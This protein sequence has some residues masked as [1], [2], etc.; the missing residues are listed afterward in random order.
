MDILIQSTK[1]FEQDLEKF[2]KIEQ[3]TI[4]KNM[5]KC[6]EFLSIDRNSFDAYSKQFKQLKLNHNYDSSL[7]SL[8][9]N[10][11]IQVILTIDDDPIFDRTLI[12]LFRVVNVE[13]AL[14]A[15]NSVAEAIYQDFTVENQEVE[16]PSS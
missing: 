11:K 1:E 15:Y 3:F 13:D 6:L 9:I 5:N 8:R 12:T 4:V 10:E 7:Y 14:K 2:S 16:V